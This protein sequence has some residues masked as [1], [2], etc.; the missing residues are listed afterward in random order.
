MA[1]EFP[2]GCSCGASAADAR[3]EHEFYRG[4]ALAVANVIRTHGDD[5]IAG[6]L[7]TEGNRTK[8]LKHADAEDLATFKEHGLVRS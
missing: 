3:E 8:L 4:Y 1:C 2:E 7:M 6:A 5:V